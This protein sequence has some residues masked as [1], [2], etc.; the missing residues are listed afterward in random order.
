MDCTVTSAH[1]SVDYLT[2]EELGD[3][4][5]VHS[6]RRAWQFFFSADLLGGHLITSDTGAAL[7]I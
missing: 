5:G 6:V 3:V 1:I 7:Q 2:F 4:A